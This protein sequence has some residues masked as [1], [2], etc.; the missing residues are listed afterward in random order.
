MSLHRRGKPPKALTAARIVDGYSRKA[1]LYTAIIVEADKI[2]EIEKRADIP[3]GTPVIDLRDAT[4]M[5]G[6]IDAHMHPPC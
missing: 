4:L 6:M 1:L 3:A 2:I 5:P